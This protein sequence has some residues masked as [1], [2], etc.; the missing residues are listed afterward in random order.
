MKVYFRFLKNHRIDLRDGVEYMPD[1]KVVEMAMS[2]RLVNRTA[3]VCVFDVG[4]ESKLHAVDLL[5]ETPKLPRDFDKLTKPMQ[6][7]IEDQAVKTAL[8]NRDKN[9]EIRDALDFYETQGVI[10]VVEADEVAV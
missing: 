3:L 5:D 1:V 2:G 4:V 10:Q 6:R 8:A 7:G 9:R